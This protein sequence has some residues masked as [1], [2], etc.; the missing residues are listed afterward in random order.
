[1]KRLRLLPVLLLGACLSEETSAPVL[2]GE[3][4]PAVLLAVSPQPDPSGRIGVALRVAA[5]GGL[6]GLQ[7]SIRY[8]PARLEYL[9]QV[10]LEGAVAMIN[11]DSAGAGLLRIVAYAPHGLPIEVTRLAFVVRATGW[12]ERLSLEPELAAARDGAAVPLSWARAASPVPGLAAP[13][14]ARR[15]GLDDWIRQVGGDPAAE[16]P[17]PMLVPG[18]GTIYGDA[19]LSGTVNTIDA[20]FTANVASGTQPLLTDLNRDYAIAANVM[21]RNLPGRGEAGDTLPPGREPDGSYVIN[22]VDALAISNTASGIPDSIVGKPVPGRVP[23]TNRAVVSGV[24]GSNR[25]LSRDTIYELDGLV[26]VANGVT[27]TIE[28]GTRLEGRPNPRSALAVLRGGRL[29]ADGT[30]LEPVVFTCGETIR[31]PG[32]WGGINLNGAA[33]LN[34][35]DTGGGNVVQCPEK[36]APGGQGIYGGCQSG[37]DTGRL[38]FVRIEYAGAAVAGGT[39]VAGLQLLGVGTGTIVEQV[40]VHRSAGPGVFVSG[41]EARLRGI[42]LT[43]NIGAGLAWSDGWRGIVQNLIVR[44]GR[45]SGHGLQGSNGAGN[46]DAEPRSRPLLWNVTLV[47][48]TAPAMPGGTGLLITEGSGIL[49]R[50]AI[51]LGA[52]GPGLDINDPAT[53]ALDGA[54]LD[55]SSTVFFGGQPDFAADAD[56]ADEPAFALLPARANLV[57]DPIL[58]GPNVEASPDLRPKPGS[59]ASPGAIPPADGFLDP[60]LAFRGAVAP[61]TSK[62]VVPWYVGWTTAWP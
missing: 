55:V 17:R 20:L 2:P 41:G 31:A 51:V 60:T 14:S 8:D 37:W 3:A 46:Q 32:C 13:A 7:G 26:Q 6:A 57:A 35:G 52:D 9:G 56:C 39:V 10:P 22:V 29:V 18:Q 5:S 28:A 47:G 16:R 42:F 30:R 36:V 59:P 27:L 24:I 4:Q 49:L 48:T 40:Q 15:M 61:I 38:R 34:N 19:N 33:V 12:R 23:A 50:N 62:A 44:R 1:M 45:V 21:P 58:V 25:T 43:D 53:C 11:A 54:F